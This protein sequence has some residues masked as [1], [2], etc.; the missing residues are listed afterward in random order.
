MTRP[1]GLLVVI[2]GLGGCAGVPT[3]TGSCASTLLDV[4]VTNA[5]PDRPACG[6][7]VAQHET[8]AT[9]GSVRQTGSQTR[10]VGVPREFMVAMI[11]LV[12]L[13]GLL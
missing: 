2:L 3:L 8:V 1:F 4:G 12:V 5:L 7:R 9:L 10:T 13:V 6:P 11:L